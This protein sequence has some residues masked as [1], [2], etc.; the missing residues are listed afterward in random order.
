MKRGREKMIMK[1]YIAYGSNMDLDQMKCRCPDAI[2]IGTSQLH[3]Y[4][5]LFKGSQ[6]GAYATIEPKAGEIVPVLVWKISEADEKNLDRYEGYPRF[7]Y[8]KILKV[9][10]Q[11]SVIDAMVYIMQEERE[12]GKPSHQ[13]YHVLE[14]A[15]EKFNFD[16]NTLIAALIQSTLQ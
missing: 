2:L 4:E 3:G 12:L 13:Y 8:K 5:L 15:Y 10:I 9:D 7:Y 11:G 6:T 14:A 1:Y 16:K